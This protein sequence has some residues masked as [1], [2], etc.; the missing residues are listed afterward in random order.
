[1]ILLIF[2]E[3]LKVSRVQVKVAETV[4]ISHLG[5]PVANERKYTKDQQKR[6]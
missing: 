6:N 2:V 5:Q 4:I 1:M 3:G